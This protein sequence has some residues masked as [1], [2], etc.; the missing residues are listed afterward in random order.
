MDMYASDMMCRSLNMNDKVTPYP[1]TAGNA[2][3]LTF[4]VGV[5]PISGKALKGPC[6][7][8]LSNVK[9]K[10]KGWAWFPIEINPFAQDRWCT[11]MITKNDNQYDVVIPEWVPS[12]TYYLRT[13]IIDLANNNVPN[14]QDFSR[15]PH[16]YVNCMAITVTSTSTTY[17]KLY[18]IP[19]IY[20]NAESKFVVD[21]NDPDTFKTYVLPGP[22]MNQT[23]ASNP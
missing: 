7:F 18:K 13:E 6:T 22:V 15:G 11:D 20:D 3:P 8:Y 4:K 14:I 23:I 2:V 16:F 19:G 21:V 9:S 5:S 12:G 10:G 17:P 1:V